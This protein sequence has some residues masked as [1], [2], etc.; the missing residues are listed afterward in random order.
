MSLKAILRLVYGIVLIIIILGG[1]S[2]WA[3]KTLG[4]SAGDLERLS[5]QKEAVADLQ[6]AFSDVV[7]PGNDYL[8]TGSADEKNL[9]AQL[10]RELQ[11]ALSEVQ[12]RVDTDTEKKLIN[13]IAVRYQDVRKIELQILDIANP[14]GNSAGAE[15]MEEMDAAAD[16]LAEELEQLHKIIREE[17][18]LT[19]KNVDNKQNVIT[20]IVLAASAIAIAIGIVI[21]QLV[22]TTVVRPLIDLSRTA[23]VIA[24]GD[25]SESVSSGAKGEVGKLV[26]A[27]NN[28]VDNL[29]EIISSVTENAKYVATTSEELSTNADEAAKAAQQVAGAIQ[30]VAKGTSE[31]T[32][33]I[34]DTTETVSLVNN[35]VQQISAGAQ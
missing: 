17:E 8:I 34:T 7:M 15:K 13:D 19:I 1:V 28:M 31:Q 16:S 18:A 6:L 14:V 5:A 10:D 35:S 32:R 24:R 26:T 12:Q 21:S 2:F 27:F 33:F 4:Q 9:H 29:R 22:K 20:I 11:E 25:L 3:V 23:E 30:E